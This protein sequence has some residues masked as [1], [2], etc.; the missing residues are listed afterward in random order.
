MKALL[1]GS[2][3]NNQNKS[4]PGNRPS[5]SI[6]LKELSAQ[7]LG[8]LIAFYENKTVFEGLIWNINSFDQEG[9][10]LGKKLTNQLLSKTS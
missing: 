4:F 3:S 1:E 6:S 10:E 8:E 9:V 2:C 7:S 5:I